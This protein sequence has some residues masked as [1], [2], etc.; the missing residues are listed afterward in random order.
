MPIDA[1]R[2]TYM[3]NDNKAFVKVIGL[4][5]L[6]LKSSCYLVLDET[7]YVPSFRGNLVYVS[8]LDKFGYSCLFGNGKVSLFQYSNMIGT[9]S[10]VGNL[11]KLNINVSRINESLHESNYGTK[12]KLTY[13]NSSMLWHKRLGHISK[14]RMDLCQ[15]E[16][17]IPLI[18]QIL[19]CVL[20]ALR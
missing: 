16:F 7:F 19:K 18:L 9:G 8:R 13:E 14:Q 10:L 1:E 11:Y 3:G 15:K 6:Q 17:L 2:F 5:R 12:R 4:F 20:I